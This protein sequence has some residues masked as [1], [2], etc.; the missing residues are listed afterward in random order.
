VHCAGGLFHSSRAD[1]QHAA[2]LG[3]RIREPSPLND[4]TDAHAAGDAP[5]T[6]VDEVADPLA[7]GHKQGYLA[8]GD[9][10]ERVRTVDP[11]RSSW[12][13]SLLPLRDH[14]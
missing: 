8:I 12:R 2:G 9:V 1:D 10:Q 5:E 13:E 4:R 14:A 6:A 11:T 7:Q 3:R